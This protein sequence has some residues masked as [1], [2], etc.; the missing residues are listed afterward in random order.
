MFHNQA[1]FTLIEIMVTLAVAIITLSVAVPSYVNFT[2]ANKL[3]TQVNSFVQAL[4]LARNEAVR[5]GGATFCASNDQL[6]CTEG[7]DWLTGW[8]IFADYDANGTKDSGEEVIRIGEAFPPGF[9]I[10]A[11]E[12]SATFGRQG[13]VVVTGGAKLPLTFSFCNGRTGDDM[14]RKIS[15]NK[16]GRPSMESYN[17]CK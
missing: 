7:G 16:A 5:A 9:V 3:T 1:G 14:G 12:T 4:H 10:T 2:R 11:D 6:D 15:I 13:F 17:D 8:I